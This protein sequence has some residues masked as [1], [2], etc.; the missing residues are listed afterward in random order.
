MLTTIKN[1]LLLIQSEFDRSGQ[2]VSRSFDYTKKENP[3]DEFELEF[4]VSS[5]PE[6]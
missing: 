6:L 1:S 3:R 4:S 2:I 5:E